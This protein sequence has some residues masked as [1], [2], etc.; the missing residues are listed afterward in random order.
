MADHL[1]L[2]REEKRFLRMATRLREDACKDRMDMHGMKGKDY[3]IA[4]DGLTAEYLVARETNQFWYPYKGDC[5]VGLHVEVRQTRKEDGCL[6]VRP[7]D[8]TD[9]D[10]F[11]VVG[12]FPY[13]RIVGWIEG[14]FAK[15]DDF[16][17][18]PAGRPPAYFVPQS[19]LKEVRQ[20]Q[21]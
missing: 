10:Y 2:C 11:L 18:A 14:G 5:D 8:N 19:A 1:R 6:I 21:P 15:D 20:W 13:L 7:K 3:K 9:A 16:I 17:Q 12:S 4:L